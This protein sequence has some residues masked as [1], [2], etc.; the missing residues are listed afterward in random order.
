MTVAAVAALA[1]GLGAASLFFPLRH[2]SAAAMPVRLAVELGSEAS[3]PTEIKPN[4]ALSP[5]GRTLA[6]VALTREARTGRALRAPPGSTV[7]SP[8]AGD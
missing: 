7:R 2:S 6:F 3:M 1:A 8:V 4:V 5:D